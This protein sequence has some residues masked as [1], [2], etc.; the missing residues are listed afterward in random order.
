MDCWGVTFEKHNRVD[1][2]MKGSA[3]VSEFVPRISSV[4]KHLTGTSGTE[5]L[6]GRRYFPAGIPQSQ[7]SGS[8]FLRR[9][10]AEIPVE[11]LDMVKARKGRRALKESNCRVKGYT[12]LFFI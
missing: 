4:S 10:N 9:T 1:T 8:F 12:V 3:S 6:V 11:V 7:C 5:C 2:Q